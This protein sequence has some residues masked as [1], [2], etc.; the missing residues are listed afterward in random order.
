M[1]RTRIQN[2]FRITALGAVFASFN[3]V[4]QS[5]PVDAT[6]DV[7]QRGGDFEVRRKVVHFADLDLS[8]DAGVKVL[9]QR[10]KAAADSVCSSLNGSQGLTVQMSRRD[11]KDTA[12]AN[13]VREIDHPLLTELHRASTRRLGEDHKFDFLGSTPAK[14][15]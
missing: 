9:Y 13:A 2:V 1:T 5:L 15:E 6:V 8:G 10:I 7:G 11:C 12:T 3:A 14:Q 4:A